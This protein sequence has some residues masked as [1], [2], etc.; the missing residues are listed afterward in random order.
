MD[1]K[2]DKILLLLEKINIR[3]DAI[4][5]HL[6]I[7]AIDNNKMNDHIDFID[8]VYDHIRLPLQFVKN[9]IDYVMGNLQDEQQDML[10]ISHA[11]YVKTK[12][13]HNELP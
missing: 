9:K 1:E 6:N 3:I 10:P 4:E 13:S 8:N 5:E 2:L 11:S 7:I 12:F